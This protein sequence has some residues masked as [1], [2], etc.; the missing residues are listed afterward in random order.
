[1]GLL[2]TMC[3]LTEFDVTEFDVMQFDVT[4]MVDSYE[5]ALERLCRSRPRLFL[6][7]ARHSLLRDF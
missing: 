3:L 2:I 1:M 6:W 5:H 7:I 4:E